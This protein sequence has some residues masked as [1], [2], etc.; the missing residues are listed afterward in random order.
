MEKWAS[1]PAPLFW[2]TMDVGA[3]GAGTQILARKIFHQK[4]SP[5]TCVV[6][7]VSATRG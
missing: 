2:V 5:Q 6:K 7:M 4:L 3:N 1:E